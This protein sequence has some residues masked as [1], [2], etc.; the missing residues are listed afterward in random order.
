MKD[1]LITVYITNYN[2]QDY[3]EQAIESVL[4]QTLKNFELFIIDDGSTDNSKDIIESYRQL[5]NVTI[6][7]QQNKGLNIT[8]NIAMRLSNSKYLMRLDADDYIEPDALEVLSNILE[9]D[10]ELGLVFPDYYYIDKKGVKIGEQKRHDF[11]KDVSLYDQP[12]H[13]ACTMIRLS[14]LKEIGGYNESFNCQDG[15]D[16]WL[17]F[18]THY[19][20][21][22]VNKP[23]FYY[24]QHGNNLTTNELRILNTRR[25]I[26]KKFYI[27]TYK[28]TKSLAIIPIREIE[29]NG[30]LWALSEFNGKSILKEKVNVCL[31]SKLISNII[32]ISESER[33]AEYYNKELKHISNCFFIKR[34]SSYSELTSPLR[35]SIHLALDLAQK[36]ELLFS[37]IVTVQ[38]EYPFLPSSAIDELIYTQTLF[39]A[40]SVISV[41]PENRIFYQHDGHSLKPIMSQDKFIKL[42]REA[43]YKSTGGLILLT[44]SSFFKENALESKKISHIVLD[45]KSSFAVFTKFD[46]DIF[47][48][49]K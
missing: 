13:G 22:N 38:I 26:K 8:N 5:D 7:Y 48:R 3:I 32:I 17:K 15:Y 42:E 41:R 16:L 47:N 2:Y 10:E 30:V 49:I 6:I 1:S 39:Q 18:I 35:K 36:K 33:I 37:N 44:K 24:R 40:D 28:L 12:A 20:V 11:N 45:E 34:P 9:L 43:L 21:T 19:K 23:L 27:D 29:Y 31:N 46:Y 4:N 25:E 14:F